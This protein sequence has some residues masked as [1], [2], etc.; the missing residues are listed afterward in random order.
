MFRPVISTVIIDKDNRPVW[1][2]ASLSDV[3]D[4]TLEESF[5]SLGENDLRL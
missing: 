1:N 5:S 4:H 2:P 3:T